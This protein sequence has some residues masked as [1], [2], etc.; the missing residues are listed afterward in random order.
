[1]IVNN[2]KQEKPELEEE[3]QNLWLTDRLLKKLSNTARIGKPLIVICLLLG[4]STFIKSLYFLYSYWSEKTLPYSEFYLLEDGNLY[5]VIIIMISIALIY[6]CTRGMLEGYK[7][8]SMLRHCE[9][10][11]E[12]L[13][14]GSERLGKMLRWLVFGGGVFGA[15]IL[16]KTLWSL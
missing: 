5:R 11:D 2:M 6:L 8:W 9:S 13:L 7:A 1:M 10:N 15:S 3:N 12:A 4:I 16:L 14:E